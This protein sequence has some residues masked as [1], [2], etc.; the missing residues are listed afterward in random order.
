MCLRARM[1]FAL[2]HAKTRAAIITPSKTANARLCKNTVIKVTA[3]ITK[4]S[5]LGMRLNVLKLAHSKVPMATIIISPVNAA[6]GSLSI[7]LDPN[8]INTRSIIAAT[9]PDNLAL[10][11]E[12][13]LIRLCPIIAQP[14]IPESNPERML[15]APCATASL[16]PL[17]LV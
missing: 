13:I 5:D 4:T 10:A 6:I 12:D 16:F 3:I 7:K 2:S 17:P 11:P 14:P 9:I 15:A 1:R 8:I